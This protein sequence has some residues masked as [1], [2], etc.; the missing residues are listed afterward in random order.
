[1]APLALTVLLCAAAPSATQ[2]QKGAAVK[3]VVNARMAAQT[4]AGAGI[5]TLRNSPHE[6][7]TGPLGFGKRFASGFGRHVVKTG[8]QAGVGGLRHEDLH[9]HRSNLHGT[10]PRLKY[11]VKSTFWVPR[12]NR[13]GKTVALGRISGNVGSGLISRAWQPASTAGLGAGL[14]TGGIGL[15]ADVG[16]HIA[17]EFWPRHKKPEHRT[18]H[19]TRPV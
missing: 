10:F 15:G 4:A 1:M 18:V 12:T 5:G 19:R 2:A 8:I 9:Y 3:R 16:V 6:W 14:A 7:G 13:T 11:A 17:Q